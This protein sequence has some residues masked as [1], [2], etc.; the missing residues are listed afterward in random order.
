MTIERGFTPGVIG[1]VAA[2]HGRYYGEVWRFDRRFEIEVARE[3]AT[4]F[5]EYDAAR[6]LAA[7]VRDAGGRVGGFIAIRAERHDPSEARLRWFILDEHLRG[8]GLGKA[9][10]TEAMAHCRAC[11]F[12]RV[13]LFTFSDLTAARAL[14]VA[15]GFERIEERSGAPWGAPIVYERFAV[16]LGA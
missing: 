2:L 5:E 14:Y 11:G 9:L 10:V 8:R 3:V 6:D 16:A 15:A 4:F 7:W 12:R 13:E 1:D